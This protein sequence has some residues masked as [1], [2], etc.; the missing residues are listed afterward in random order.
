M[1]G[2]SLPVLGWGK[3]PEPPY[4]VAIFTSQLSED[5]EGFEA[6]AERLVERVREQPGFLAMDSVE[7]AN[8]IGIIIAYWKDEESIRKWKQHLEH[9]KAQKLGRE[10][11][12]KSYQV[13]IGRVERAY[14]F[15]RS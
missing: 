8:G 3:T 4:Y 1:S 13:R 6:M 5:V 15:D 10:R 14:G 9:L 2:S 12:F 7:G 11:W